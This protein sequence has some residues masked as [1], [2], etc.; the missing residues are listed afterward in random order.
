MKTPDPARRSLVLASLH[1][2][3]LGTAWAGEAI[4]SD[5]NPGPNA[6]V[7]ALLRAGGVVLV[8]RHAQAPGTFDP[9]EFRLGDCRTQ[10]NLN[11]EG[12]AQAQR[13]G[14]WFRDQKLKP[15][16]VRSSPWCRC[17][18]TATLAFGPGTPQ[19][20]AALGSPR[21]SDAAV[22]RSRKGNLQQ[23][24]AAVP[25]GRFDVW[26]TH[27]FVISELA[28]TGAASGEGL[29]LRA[30]RGG[31]AAEVLARLVVA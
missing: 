16:A 3:L 30:R 13:L 27:N 23:A 17:Q 20:W 2:G 22:N 31:G 25:A 7:A 15:A 1:T 26:V 29:V 14:Q 11:D 9:P 28:A 4:V 12:R 8:V 19:T 10:R 18:D 5:V 6:A 24:M 21:A